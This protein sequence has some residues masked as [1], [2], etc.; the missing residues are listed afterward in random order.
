MADDKSD[1]GEF[2]IGRGRNK[3]A[4]ADSFEK[5]GPSRTPPGRGETAQAEIDLGGASQRHSESGMPERLRRKYYVAEAG[6]RDEA[7]AYADPRGEYLAF[8]V[9]AERLATRLEDVGVIRDMVSIAQHRGWGEVQVRGSVEFRRTAWLESSVRGLAVRGYEPDPIDRAALS[10]RTKSDVDPARSR[11]Q[12]QQRGP[13]A[14]ETVFVA[15]VSAKRPIDVTVMPP[16]RGVEPTHPKHAAE[17]S[18]RSSRDQH[19]WLKAGRHRAD[20]PIDRSA[21]TIDVLPFRAATSDRPSR[22]AG[23]RRA[24]VFRSAHRQQNGVDDVVKAAR[25]QM[26]AIEQALAKAVLDPALRQSVLAHAE[27]R[28]AEQLERGGEFKHA[29][30]RT[31]T[32]PERPSKVSS[33]SSPRKN[34]PDTPEAHWDR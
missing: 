28:I 8:K 14:S 15:G 4:N 34:R 27:A 13:E 22:T 6:T 21:I 19:A 31:R 1:P 17:G 9:S 20:P 11:S 10:F 16:E 5:H 3:G 23:E 25:S 30:V 12:S 26:T 7:N 18:F 32:K 29:E 33:V 24:D 2:S